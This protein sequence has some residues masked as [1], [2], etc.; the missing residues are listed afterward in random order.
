VSA[1]RVP[2][3][4]LIGARRA[5][6]G[7][8]PYVA[9]DLH[10]L[11]LEVA[12]VLGTSE[13]TVGEAVRQL[14]ESYGIDAEPYTDRERM[15]ATASL[16]ALAVLSPAA[17]HEAH[18]EAALASG[19]HVLCEKPL[20]WGG[21]GVFG[22]GVS[23]VEAFRSRGLILFENCQWPFTL[24]AF[25]AL[26]PEAPPGPPSRFAM[27]LSPTV[28]G[29]ELIGDSLPHPISML[30][31]LAPDPGARIAEIHV[32][33]LS[34]AL[35][36]ADFRFTYRAA[37]AEIAC[38]VVLRHGR[39]QPREAGYALDGRGATRALSMPDY[40]M[41]FRDG[42]RSVPLPEPLTACLRQFT[43]S[44]GAVLAGATPPDPWPSAQRLQMLESLLVA[45]RG[46]L[47]DSSK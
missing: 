28:S 15:L 35:E 41:E 24:P 44:L 47:G 9:R 32:E 42:E 1:S 16:D 6:Q 11:G 37:G 2:R 40:S 20:L 45:S 4:G 7:T 33:A 26:H 14:A 10:A 18:L 36:D 27:R 38:E 43:T 12:A 22:R 46:A 17:T 13:A 31:A 23:L 5:R 3:I 30:Q 8:G 21:S 25:H 29:L 34:S 19:L 39:E